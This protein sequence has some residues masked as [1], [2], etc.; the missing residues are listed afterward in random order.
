MYNYVYIDAHTHIYIDTDRERYIYMY[1]YIHIHIYI[2]I[3]IYIAVMW[4]STDFPS[5]QLLYETSLTSL[6]HSFDP[7]RSQEI[8]VRPRNQEKLGG[9]FFFFF[10]AREGYTNM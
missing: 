1:I 8:V 9:E 6:Q 2:Y 4:G 7:H 3:Y 10:K 5:H